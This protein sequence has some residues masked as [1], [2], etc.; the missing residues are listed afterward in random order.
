MVMSIYRKLRYAHPR[1]ATCPLGRSGKI[2]TG[3]ATPANRAAI[4]LCV[5]TP[6]VRTTLFCAKPL[7]ELRPC[8]LTTCDVQ[9][10]CTMASWSEWGQCT[11]E[12][13][14]NGA[15]VTCGSAQK[16]RSREVQ[17]HASRDGLGCTEPM[18]ELQLCHLPA[19][20][21]DEP[22]DC[23]W[24][25]WAEWD[26]CS[27]TCGGGS[28]HRHRHLLTAPKKPW[29][30]LR[31]WPGAGGEA[32]QYDEL[33]RSVCEWCLARLVRLGSLCCVVWRRCPN[34]EP[35]GGGQGDRLWAAFDRSQLQVRLLQ[36]TAVRRN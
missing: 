34:A 21:G 17:T 30:L 32:L 9:N 24:K 14:S 2:A 8:S 5:E 27:R 16:R 7:S 11:N 20:P 3:P 15:P 6:S 33:R 19:C 29:G 13:G 12:P 18:V 31:A 4:E 25:S 10:D 26:A 1:S 35:L 23:E 22:I 28:S 36:Y